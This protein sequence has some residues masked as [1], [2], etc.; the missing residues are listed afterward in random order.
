MK[1]EEPY[2][3]FLQTKEIQVAKVVDEEMTKVKVKDFNKL[4]KK[5]RKLMLT[6][7]DFIIKG[8]KGFVSFIRS[9]K[10]HKLASI[11][12]VDELDLAEIAKSFFL[13]KIPFMKEFKETSA[14]GNKIATDHELALLEKIEFKNKNQEKMIQEKIKADRQKSKWPLGLLLNRVE[15]S[16]EE[17]G[18]QKK[19]QEGTGE[20]EGEESR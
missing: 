6:D 1:N 20:E 16:G 13:F 7:K 17:E 9:Y 3:N 8:S 15:E 19:S 4:V 10:E 11:L 5:M 12:K 14:E 18:H 2:L